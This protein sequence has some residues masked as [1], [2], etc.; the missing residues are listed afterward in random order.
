MEENELFFL[1]FFYIVYLFF[2]FFFG[3]DFF[4]MVDPSVAEVGLGGGS[5]SV[6][7]ICN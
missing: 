6:I 5:G 4:P 1:I 2:S 7:C 3:V